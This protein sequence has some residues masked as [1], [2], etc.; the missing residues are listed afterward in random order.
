MPRGRRERGVQCCARAELQIQS[1]SRGQ[2]NRDLP[3]EPEG[4]EKRGKS[5]ETPWQGVGEM[6]HH[7]MALPGK[8]KC[9][10]CCRGGF[11]LQRQI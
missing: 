11:D 7:G 2:G 5:R 4:A 1:R 10:E 8:L 9:P 3:L 6:K